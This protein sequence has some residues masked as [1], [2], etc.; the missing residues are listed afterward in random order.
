MSLSLGKYNLDSCHL[1]WN[2]RKL[3]A[4]SHFLLCGAALS[5]CFYSHFCWSKHQHF[6]IF[7]AIFSTLSVYLPSTAHTC[8]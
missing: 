6:G 7:Y 4:L 1:C 2:P 8:H 3:W 5:N